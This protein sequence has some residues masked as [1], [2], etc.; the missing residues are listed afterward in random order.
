MT[1]TKN[2][3]ETLQARAQRDRRFRQAMLKEGVGAL[4]ASD[5]STGQAI[6][7]DYIYASI[8]FGPL[9]DAT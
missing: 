8:G 2:F 6:L 7:R 3:C 5:V 1:L 4:L 9:A